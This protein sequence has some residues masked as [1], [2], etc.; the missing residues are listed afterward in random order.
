MWVKVRGDGQW[1]MLPCLFTRTTPLSEALASYF[2]KAQPGDLIKAHDRFAFFSEDLRWEGNLTALR[3]G[4]GYLFRRLGL[5]TVVIPFYHQT[6]DHA[7]KKMQVTEQKTTDH[8]HNPAAA[9]NMTMIA[10]VNGENGANDANDVLKV[11]VNDEL[12]G[13]AEPY[14][15]PSLSTEGA[16]SLSEA[17]PLYFLTIQSDKTGEL[18]FEIDGK[19]YVPE[20][21]VV[22]YAA[23]AH[24]G[25]LK[26]PIILR[27]ADGTGVYK[28]IENNHVVIIRNNEKYDVTGK[29]LK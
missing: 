4:E 14:S 16:S 5:G 10:K 11:Y 28:I 12:V 13:V 2:Q 23:D 3:P 21:G 15:I 1:S 6:T 24:Y 7:P 9:T 17:S 25:T 29:K 26:A 18:K 19:T 8:F 22:N 27:P 20:S